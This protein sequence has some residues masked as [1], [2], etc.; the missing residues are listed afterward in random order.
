ML[1]I[2]TLSDQDPRRGR[3]I[4]ALGRMVDI[5]R[6]HACGDLLPFL[7]RSCVS[8]VVTGVRDRA[9][10][11][12]APTLTLVRSEFPRLPI[13]A[14]SDASASSL[15]S[16]VPLV[17]AGVDELLPVEPAGRDKDLRDALRRAFA[18]RGETHA[19]ARLLPLM[20]HDLR[21]FVAYCFAN[22]HEATSVSDAARTL[23][24]HR[25]TIANRLTAAGLPSARVLI[26]LAR[27][28]NAACL[29]DA[30]HW[31]IEQVGTVCGFGG[32]PGL[33]NFLHRHVG[34]WPSEL[35]DLGGANYVLARVASV[36]SPALRAGELTAIPQG[37]GDYPDAALASA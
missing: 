24:I 28:Y 5:V 19:L 22:G 23:S 8:G 7:R 20:P 11:I 27:L 25:S 16:I 10:Q 3:V 6:V 17:R 15:A 34:I 18:S 29:L 35:R 12:V 2:C 31:T 9:G 26:G 4:D 32:G 36:L 1:P 13:L 21:A 14:V 37:G 30:G 33:S